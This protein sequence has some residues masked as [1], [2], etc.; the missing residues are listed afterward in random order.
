MPKDFRKFKR[1][2]ENAG[3]LVELNKSGHYA[4]KT[5]DGFF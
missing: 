1:E 4:V 2:I 5:K 3:Y